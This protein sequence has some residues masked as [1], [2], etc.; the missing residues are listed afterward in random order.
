M[1]VPRQ[2]SG[3]QTQ[4]GTITALQSWYAIL[5][6]YIKISS[7]L[8]IIAHIGAGPLSK[9]IANSTN[10]FQLTLVQDGVRVTNASITLTVLAPD[11]VTKTLNAATVPHIDNGVYLLRTAASV[12]PKT[13]LGYQAAFIITH[14][15]DVLRPKYFFDVSES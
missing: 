14:G 13:G 15:A 6:C 12:L 4:S 2:V 3:T 5:K 11:G 7:V 8:D 9:P 1:I 10:Q